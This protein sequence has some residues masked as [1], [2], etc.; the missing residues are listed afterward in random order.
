MPEIEGVEHDM[1]N[2]FGKLPPF[3][4]SK[5]RT[6][7]PRLRWRLAGLVC[8]VRG[9]RP[10]YPDDHPYRSQPRGLPESNWCRR[11]LAGTPD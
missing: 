7:R 8:L 11:C 1:P 9:H 10:A 3:D 4:G 6:S 5:V 2:R